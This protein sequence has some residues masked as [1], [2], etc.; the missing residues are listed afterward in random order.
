MTSQ[1]ETSCQSIID[2]LTST[3]ALARQSAANPANHA[4]ESGLGDISSS[5]DD[6]II[7]LKTWQTSLRRQA[8]STTPSP[9]AERYLRLISEQADVIGGEVARYTHAPSDQRHEWKPSQGF[10]RARME[11]KALIGELH[12][13]TIPA[14]DSTRTQREQIA[15]DANQQVTVLEELTQWFV[16]RLRSSSLPQQRVATFAHQP[17][18]AG[19]LKIGSLLFLWKEIPTVD[20]LTKSNIASGPHDGIPIESS[21]VDKAKMVLEAFCEAWKVLTPKIEDQGKFEDF[22]NMA[23]IATI[24]NHLPNGPIY[25]DRFLQRR[26]N[27]DLIPFDTTKLNIIF[28]GAADAPRVGDLFRDQQCR[29][30]WKEWPE[31]THITFRALEPLPLKHEEIYSRDGSY[32]VVDKVRDLTCQS[33]AP[34]FYARKCQKATTASREHLVNEVATLKRLKHHHILRYVKSY[35]RGNDEFAFLATPAADWCLLSLLNQYCRNSY[36]RA[37]LKPILLR[38]FGCISL[39]LDYLHNEAATRHRDIKPDNILY[40]DHRYYIADFGLAY[41][42]NPELGSGT[43]GPFQSTEYYRAPE[44]DSITQPHGRSTDVFS[45]GCTFLEILSAM[46]QTGTTEIRALRIYADHLDEVS[47]WVET[48]SLQERGRDEPFRS[49]L[50]LAGKM[51]SRDTKQRPTIRAVIAELQGISGKFKQPLFCDE[52]AMHLPAELGMKGQAAGVH[53]EV[54]SVNSAQSG[55][56]S[57]LSRKSVRSFLKAQKNKLHNALTKISHREERD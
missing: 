28:S 14:A 46:I 21:H 57:K 20:G 42:F 45:L 44:N 38:T 25:F 24:L 55:H 41:H 18:T 47:K 12:T 27:D 56:S 16:E 13:V 23:R 37:K 32:S 49:L 15:R 43:L 6:S 11:I 51:V 3:L 54:E 10:E 36:D 35:E 9:V 50:M 34:R 29:A 33:S 48:A 1:L 39:G 8:D 17:T 26:W 7:G 53:L 2:K 31:G 52:C 40:H 5:A 19:Q 30:R 22:K 4:E